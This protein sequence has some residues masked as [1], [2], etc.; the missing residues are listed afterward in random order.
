MAATGI[1]LTLIVSRPDGVEYRRAVVPDQGIGGRSLDVGL[2]GSAPTG[3]WRVRAYTDP[4]RPPVG[5]ATFMVEDYVPDRLEFTLA[6][7]TGTISKSQGA[8]VTVDGRYLYGA[9]AAGLGLEGE[10]V[11]LPTRERPQWKGY[12]FGLADEQAEPTREPIADLPA[13]DNRGKAAF[14]VELDKVPAT[15]R[16]LQAQVVVRM[17]EAGGRAVERTADA[18]GDAGQQR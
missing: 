8:K 7:P 2:V 16:P 10:V 12:E 13:A 17:A 3:T 9:P 6:S 4:K 18:A 11:V 15:T 14:T 5:E 1:P